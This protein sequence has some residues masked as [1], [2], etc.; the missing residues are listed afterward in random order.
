MI[1]ACAAGFLAG[2]VH[3]FAGADHLA[4]LTPL[5]IRARRS[6]WAVGF[7]WGLGHSSGVLLVALLAFLF[8]PYINLDALSGWG[9]RL[10]GATM[11]LLGA[12]GLRRVLRD[13]IQPHVH[14]H[15]AFWVGT[16]HGLAG[17]AHLLGVLPGLSLLMPI[18]LTRFR[19]L[20][21]S[22]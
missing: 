4:A 19:R 12:A 8:R 3:V 16:L 15:M 6:A 20:F 5:S 10:V 7:R 13:E 14:T 21:L 9:E 18:S 1:I 22:L 2:L 17:T 11:I